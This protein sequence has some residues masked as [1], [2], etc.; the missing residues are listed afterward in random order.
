MLTKTNPR[1][2]ITKRSIIVE[3]LYQDLKD[4]LQ[5]RLVTRKPKLSR[6]IRTSEIHRPGLAFSGFYDYFAYDHVQILGKTEITYLLHL[7]EDKWGRHLGR[8]FGYRVPC[9]IIAKNQ[10]PPRNLL[11]LAEAASVPVFRSPLKTSTISS[12]VTVYIEEMIAPETTVHGTLLDVYGVGTILMGESGV[13]K[14]ECALELI[15]RGHRLV[16]DDVVRV[17]QL[18]S[19]VLMG[20][21]SEVIR[22]HMEIRGLGI[23]DVTSMFGAGAVRHRKRISLAVTLVKWKDDVHYDRLGLED[24]TFKL[25]NAKVPHVALP[26]KPGRNIPVLVEAAALCQRSKQMGRHAPQELNRH[27]MAAMKTGER[28]KFA[29]GAGP[30]SKSVIRKERAKS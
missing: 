21:S 10:R 26:V 17:R 24:E 28:A 4:E 2:L 12:R 3:R 1:G 7:S 23:I 15:E 19:K 14:S 13:G 30:R 20:F 5:L 9:M 18:G 25:M 29:A 22:H 8:F 16:A 11:A 6:R 27:I